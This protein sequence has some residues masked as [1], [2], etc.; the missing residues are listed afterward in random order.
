MRIFA[1]AVQK[2]AWRSVLP[3]KSKASIYYF[4][5]SIYYFVIIY[6]ELFVL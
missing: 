3:K 5:R 6:W 2:Y 1:F 4:V